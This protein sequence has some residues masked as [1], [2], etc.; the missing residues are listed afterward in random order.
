MA[1]SL[2]TFL[3]SAVLLLVLGVSSQAAFWRC[4]LPGGIYMVS[5]ASVASVSTHEYIVDGVARVTEL[6]VA[7]NSAVIARFY[8]LEPV[9]SKSP[10][11]FGNSLLEKAHDTANELSERTGTEP[12]WLK[13][14][15]NYPTTTHAHT[16]E[17]RLENVDQIK[18]LQA[19]LEEA[20]R[21]GKD[22]TIKIK[23]TVATNTNAAE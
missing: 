3:L 22:T 1:H 17:Y 5:L 18:K 13:V 2:K 15:K 16:V 20:L 14:V 9:I 19:S 10:V 4:E 6:T 12:V 23:A 8:Y 21:L 11:G 7:T